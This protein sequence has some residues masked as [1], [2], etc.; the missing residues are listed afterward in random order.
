MIFLQDEFDELRT[1]SKLDQPVATQGLCQPYQQ[2]V[3]PKKGRFSAPKWRAT[4][5]SAPQ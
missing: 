3:H 4:G 2:G 5:I 1:R